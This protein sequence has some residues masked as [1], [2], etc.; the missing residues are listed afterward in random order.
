MGITTLGLFGSYH[1]VFRNWPGASSFLTHPAWLGLNVST[2]ACVTVLQMLAG[3]G[4]LAFYQWVARA[5]IQRGIMSRLPRSILW[6]FILCSIGWAW[7]SYWTYK[8]PGLIIYPV[9]TSLSLILVAISVILMIAGCFEAEEC[10]W[11]VVLGAI[12]LGTVCVLADGVG[13]NARFILQQKDGF[14]ATF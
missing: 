9:L 13:W 11:Y 2:V 3:L 14:P 5:K 6:C 1:Y 4:F 12:L 10:P 7:V 8:H